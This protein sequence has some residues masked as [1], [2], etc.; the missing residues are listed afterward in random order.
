MNNN[1]Y[2]IFSYFKWVL[3]GNCLVLHWLLTNIQ[4][5][6]AKAPL[7]N[8]LMFWFFGIFFYQNIFFKLHFEENIQIKYNKI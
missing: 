5:V 4:Q 6:K 7:W 3:N 2:A 8:L 1:N